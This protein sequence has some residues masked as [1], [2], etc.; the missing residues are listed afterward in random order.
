VLIAGGGTA[1]HVNPALALAAELDGHEVYFVGTAGGAEATL[2]P[3]AGFELDTIEVVGLDRARPLAAPLVAFKALRAMGE[4]RRLLRRRRP[5]VVVGV[6]GYASLPVGLAARLARIP[7]VIHEQNAVL[8]LANRVLKPV[9]AAIALSFEDT[10]ARA[11]R[12][13]VVTGNPVLPSIAAF[14]R[15]AL[16][17]RA[18]ERFDLNA[19]APVVLL[20]GGSQGAQ[21]V[22]QAAAGLATA[23]RARGDVQVV[24][25]TGRAAHAEVEQAVASALGDGALIYRA[26]PFVD[27]MALAYAAADVAVCRGGATTVAELC[28]VGLPAVIVPYPHHRD[29]QQER[30]ALILE[31]AGAALHLPDREAS[32]DRLAVLLDELLAAP[33][34]LREMA[35]AAKRLGR[36]DAARRLAAVVLGAAR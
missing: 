7:V 31:R 22:N 2:V 6:G 28:A 15:D 25:I 30:H 32:A 16:R 5:S 3:A 11:G 29:R 36:P 12:R 26:L 27:D 4:A 19:T 33:G 8:G 9:A 35:A 24:H 18:L 14:E 17:P 1:G 23:W 10:L 21:R 20:F 13:A 34:R